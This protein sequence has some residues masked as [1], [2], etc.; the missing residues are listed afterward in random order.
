[1][2]SGELTVNDLADTLDFDRSVITRHLSHLVELHVLEKRRR[3]LESGGHVYIYTPVEPAAIRDR[4][5]RLFLSWVAQAGQEIDS[6]RR[7]KVEAIAQS[8]SEETPWKI[9]QTESQ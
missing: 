5:R 6:L 3:L 1:M 2:E 8:S 9:F 7:E 4:F